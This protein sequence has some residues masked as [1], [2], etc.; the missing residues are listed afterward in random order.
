MLEERPESIGQQKL[1]FLPSGT[2]ALDPAVQWVRFCEDVMRLR[3]S[4]PCYN[5]SFKC[6]NGIVLDAHGPTGSSSY[7]SSFESIGTQM[8]RAF[9]DKASI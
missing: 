4:I 2:N 6:Y 9:V 5:T 3:F 7:P 8:T 1:P